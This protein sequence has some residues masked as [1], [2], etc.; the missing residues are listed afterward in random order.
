MSTAYRSNIEY[1][2]S[3]QEKYEYYL[4]GLNFT[5]LALSIQTAKFGESKLPVVLELLG[6]SC[7]LIA[8]VIALLRFRMQ[9]VAHKNIALLQKKRATLE[10]CRE[11]AQRG[12]RE[13]LLSDADE[14]I[15]IDEAI[16][17][18]EQSISENEPILQNL[19]NSLILQARWHL[20]LFIG[21]FVF[22]F[23]ARAYEPVVKLCCN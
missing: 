10:S 19:E 21:G 16:R 12:T 1:A 4:V 11:G 20:A 9:P 14:I 3:L 2:R 6:W 8:G 5:L 7:L 22:I 17:R 18:I 23:L 13:V 15:P